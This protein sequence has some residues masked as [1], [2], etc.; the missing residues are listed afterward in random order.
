MKLDKINLYYVVTFS[1]PTVI[2]IL[3]IERVRQGGYVFFT[4]STTIDYV[5]QRR[6]CNTMAVGG[7]LNI[8]AYGLATPLGSKYRD[9]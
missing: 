8:N 9:M 3:G 1:L 5:N 7:L 2:I 6:P 4:Q